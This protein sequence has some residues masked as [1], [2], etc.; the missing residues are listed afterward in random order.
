MHTSS[1]IN[2]FTCIVHTSSC[3]MTSCTQLQ[4]QPGDTPLVQDIKE[5]KP[6]NLVAPTAPSMT[7][8]SAIY[9]YMIAS[10]VTQLKNST[11][12]VSTQELY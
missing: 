10:L 6:A 11:Q 3:L 5:T 2:I 7:R 12:P 4:H 1:C 8:T 9:A